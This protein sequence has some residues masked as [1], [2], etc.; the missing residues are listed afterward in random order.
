MDSGM[1]I[2][3]RYLIDCTGSVIENPCVRV[4]DGHI[5]AI[6]AEKPES[7]S[8]EEL[9]DLGD[10]SILTPGLVNAHTHLE[11][12]LAQAP[13]RRQGRFT[14][15]I[16]DVMRS[17]GEWKREQYNQSLREGI[18]SS[19]RS[20]TTAAGDIMRQADERIYLDFP[21]R[22]VV[23]LEVID[24]NP[25]NAESAVAALKSR[26]EDHL[27]AERVRI[28]ISPHTPYTVS[29]KLLRECLALAR[30]GGFP[31][32]IHLSE[33]EAESEFLREGTGEILHFRKEFGLPE[34]WKPP[35]KSPVQYIRDLGMLEQ[36]ALLVHC[37]Y[38]DEDDIALIADS[39]SSV[40]FCPRSHAYFGH[41]RHTVAR[42]IEKGVNVALGTDSLASSPSLDMLDE[43]KYI[44]D[45]YGKDL[46]PL[47][48]LQMA[49]RNGLKALSFPHPPKLLRPGSPA[50]ITGIAVAPEDMRQAEHPLE[51]VFKD[52]ART[53]FS[54]IQGEVV[55]SAAQ[56]GIRRR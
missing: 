24:F 7:L 6:E 9:I 28:G 56:A 14:D 18:R 35:G 42:M 52:S 45:T 11:L 31:L 32:C 49:T 10:H 17:T 53:V 39:G 4:A 12:S 16:R 34:G 38:V 15:W 23:F 20:G 29:E 30:E 26:L 19:L 22:T 43:M 25:W 50:D 37:N 41:R 5:A 3:S 33:T 2:R 54:L 8:L 44:N 55:F 48:I 21:L 36:P 40:V 1:I 27:P 46:S 13:A 51:A 47:A